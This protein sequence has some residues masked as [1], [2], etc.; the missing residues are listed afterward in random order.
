MSFA[1][2][3]H[4]GP[5][6]REVRAL[7]RAYQE[8][9]VRSWRHRWRLWRLRAEFELTP[10]D[11]TSWPRTFPDGRLPDC[12]NCGDNC[13]R[14]PYS[15]VLLRLVDVAL[16]VDRG[17]TDR[18]TLD[19]PT[20]SPDVLRERPELRA[21]VNSFH[22]RVFP[23]LKQRPN[24]T[25]TFL[26]EDQR[27]SIHADRPWVCRTFPY[28][29]NIDEQSI[30]WSPRC[31]WFT[32]AEPSHPVAQELRHAIVHNF[33]TEKVCDLTLLTVYREELDAIG[34]TPWLNL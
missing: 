26:D 27:C 4:S 14:G 10:P 15:T 7:W 9:P 2:V 33:Y 1:R 25:C 18:F 23:V 12:A 13:C 6:E 20:F 34:I 11:T 22:W 31:R 28:R 21:M 32:E 5:L 17:W 8:K 29:L 16:F 30:G 19:K 24:G 3:M